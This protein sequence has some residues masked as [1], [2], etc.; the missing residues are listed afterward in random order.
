MQFSS[1]LYSSF[2]IDYQPLDKSV[3]TDYFVPNSEWNIASFDTD[4][5]YYNYSCCPEPYV[6]LYCHLIIVRKPL[7]YIMNV[8]IPTIIIAAIALAG[9]FCPSSTS[10]KLDGQGFAR[11]NSV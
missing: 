2:K 9:F 7:Y 4:R 11:T 6:S 8:I 5:H 3:L 10:G 1:W